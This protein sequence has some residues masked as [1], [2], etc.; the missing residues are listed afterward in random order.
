M[1]PEHVVKVGEGDGMDVGIE[2]S[3]CYTKCIISLY[4]FNII[5]QN[6]LH[7][8]DIP[9]SGQFCVRKSLLHNPISIYGNLLRY[10]ILMT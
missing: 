7:H 6:I 4:I 1:D 5:Q 2:S 10:H 8:S 3:Q 9:H